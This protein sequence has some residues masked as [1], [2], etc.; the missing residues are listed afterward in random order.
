LFTGRKEPKD[1]LNHTWE[2][3][4]QLNRALC[5]EENTGQWDSSYEDST[6]PNEKVMDVMLQEFQLGAANENVSTPT[7]SVSNTNANRKNNNSFSMKDQTPVDSL[8]KYR[9]RPGA[10]RQKEMEKKRDKH[11]ESAV[12]LSGKGRKNN[13]GMLQKGIKKN[14]E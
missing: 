12:V 1:S 14:G 6:K 13:D 10:W 4:V 11:I 7:S 5:E 3:A 2:V 8:Q 9:T